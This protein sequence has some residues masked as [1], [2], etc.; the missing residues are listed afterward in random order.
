MF[1]N[2]PSPAVACTEEP[3][4]GAAELRRILD[5]GVVGVAVWDRSGRIHAA[6]DRFLEIVDYDRRDVESGGL[7]MARLSSA[8]WETSASGLLDALSRH[9]IARGV[10]QEYLRRDGTRICV[11]LHSTFVENADRLLSIVVD[12]TEQKRAEEERDA[13]LEREQ[14]A[15]AVA[16]S[17]VR[18]R[19]D[20]LAIVSHD[21]RNPLNIVAMSADLIGSEITEERK[22]AQL[23]IMRRAIAG[24]NGLIE[25]L[26]DVSQI[27]SE[28]FSVAPEP[29]DAASF[30]DDARG[31][32][33]PLL[34]RKNQRFE[35][36]GLP[37]ALVVLADRRRVSQVLSNL[38][39]NA[40]KFT[41]EGGRITLDVTP[42]GEF[43]RFAVSDTGPGISRHDL[44]H[45]FDRFWQARRV[46]RGGV[47]LGLAITKGIVEA[48]GGSISAESHAG[49]GTTFVF[50]LPRARDA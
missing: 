37:H 3:T 47:G 43:A 30:L 40:T 4:V 19:D 7:C 38:I 1:E 29:V 5:S 50:T 45:I 48:H 42:S 39:G 9:G 27:A 41:P 28:S 44:A 35:C 25:D 20:I 16:E 15:R 24:M 33:E 2:A 31:M 14:L 8:G 10:E 26:L 12:V 17:A 46:R 11:K 34:A 22:A 49:V 18:A 6:N 23:A 13:L 36:A 21:L 32:F